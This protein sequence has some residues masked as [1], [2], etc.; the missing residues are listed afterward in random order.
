MSDYFN[1]PY[2]DF[3]NEEK[4]ESPF[5]EDEALYET[6][7]DDYQLGKSL[8]KKQKK[9]LKATLAKNIDLMGLKIGQMFGLALSKLRSKNKNRNALDDLI[10]IEEYLRHIS[11]YEQKFNHNMVACLVRDFR[12]GL[13]HW[14]LLQ[15][16]KKQILKRRKRTGGIK[17]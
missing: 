2:D 16:W 12:E 3:D 13:N 5:I 6:L 4:K 10:D 1:E 9:Q 14:D 17:R 8:S 11:S 15:D 7:L